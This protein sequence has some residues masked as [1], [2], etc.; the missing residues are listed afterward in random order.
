MV[1]IKKALISV[2]DK[3][4]MTEFARELEALGIEIISTGG[5]SKALKE[6]GIKLRS[7]S[8]LTGAGEMLDGRVKTLHP[9]IHGGLLAARDNRKH[10]EELKKAGIELIDMVV[11]NL[12]P[13]EKVIAE[14]SVVLEDAVENIDIG[15]PALLRAA[16]KNYKFVAAVSN[17][18][19]YVGIIEELK[20]NDNHLS[21]MTLSELAVEVF[22]VT[23]GYDK[24]I[25]DFLR[26]RLGPVADGGGL[27]DNE[28]V[29]SGEL[30]LRL[31]KIQDLRYGEN[32]HQKAAFYRDDKVTEPS[33]CS[34]KQLS[35]K[36]LSF[37]NIMDLNAAIE[38]IKDFEKPAAC[39]LK[40]NNPCGA[41]LSF[42]LASAYEKA[43]ESDPLSAF[44]GIVGL[45]KVV[46]ED[47]AGLINSSRFIE[48]VIAPGYTD[49]AV[50]ILKRKKN[51]RILD[52]PD[53][54]KRGLDIDIKKVTGGM[55]VQEKDVVKIEA[56]DLKVVTRK[57]P[58]PQEIGS[59]LFAWH[60]C[61]YV[62]SNAIVLADGSQAVG[63]GAGQMSRVDSVIIAIKKAG[64]RVR[65]SV[66]ASDAFFPMKDSIEKAHKAGVKAIIQPGGSIRDEEVIKEADAGQIAM[67]FTG[68]RHFKH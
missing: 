10:M 53:M 42:N 49:K 45:N 29:F 3:S 59:L 41:A 33:V 38:L 30:E 60:I 17:A 26:A 68:I 46:D 20:D 27:S 36:E 22:E 67:V 44:G 28:F 58:T 8:E 13:F 7:V 19:R 61:K 57:K 2:S 37:N 16:A 1:K 14:G 6:A 11:V 55:L 12:Y 15:G 18:D 63:I 4:G 50:E 64:K 65:G 47:T 48:C 32:P 56:G 9:K 35:G 25:S 39:I 31:K 62:K 23:A 34:L 24:K 52:I 40:H 5:T 51:V 54:N 43:L 66:M 21:E